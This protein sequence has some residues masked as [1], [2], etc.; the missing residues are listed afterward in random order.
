MSGGVEN[1][2]QERLSHKSVM[3]LTTSVFLI[4]II[5]GSTISSTI[6]SSSNSGYDTK[7]SDLL[8]HRTIKYSGELNDYGDYLENS[9]FIEGDT[10]RGGVFLAQSDNFKVVNGSVLHFNLKEEIWL[11]CRDGEIKVNTFFNGGFTN[12]TSPWGK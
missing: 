4:G 6:P 9:M 5:L 12:V 10:G 8:E 3:L 7:C 11:E 1:N 2:R